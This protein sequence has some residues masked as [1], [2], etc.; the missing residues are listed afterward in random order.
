MKKKTV[1]KRR[2]L[3]D[4][5][6]KIKNIAEAIFWIFRFKT[7]EILII[8]IIGLIIFFNVSYNKKDGLVIRPGVKVEVK[9]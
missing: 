9:K 3:E 6:P 4:K 2:R 8:I 7:K 1:N 5:P